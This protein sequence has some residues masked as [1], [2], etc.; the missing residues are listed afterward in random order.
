[1]GKVEN[2]VQWMIK[3]A[4]DNSNGYD[5]NNRW[6]KDWDCSSFIIQ[7]FEQAG[8][9]VKTAGATYTGNMLAVFQK[10]GFKKVKISERKRGDVLLQHNS[11]TGK[12]HTACVLDYN[13]LVHASINELGTA[14]GGKTG[15]QTGREICVAKYYSRPW[16]YCLRYDEDGTNAET[17]EA[18][19]EKPADTNS[20]V[21]TVKA[22]DTLWNIAKAHGTTVKRLAEIN[23][24]EDA[25]KIYKGQKIRIKNLYEVATQKDSLRI[26]NGRGTNHSILGYLEKGAQVEVENIQNGWAKLADRAGYVSAEYLKRI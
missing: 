4:N 19:P 26:R 10:C 15:D 23:E 21:Y 14:T 17:P 20:N 11:K 12:G 18:A 16:D 9:K 22:G 25:D 1:M 8:I 24:I 7:G 13:T 2:A 5:Q 3:I 6:G